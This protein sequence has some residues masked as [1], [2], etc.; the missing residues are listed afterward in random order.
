[1]TNALRLLYELPKKT[2]MS[3]KFS[4]IVTIKDK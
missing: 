2:Q 3:I 1:M 4:Y